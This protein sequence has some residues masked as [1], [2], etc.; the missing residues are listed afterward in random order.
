MMFPRFNLMATADDAGGA[1]V[2]DA[3]V[4]AA[5]PPADPATATPSTPNAARVALEAFR[6]KRAEKAAARTPAARDGEP[7]VA[8]V[9]PPELKSAADKWAA[10]EKAESSRITKAAEGLDDEDKALIAGEPDIT[11][12]AA[13]L[14][15]LSRAADASPAPKPVAK[16]KPAGG[17][18]SSSAVDF[19]AALKDPRAMADAKA[20]DP[21]GFEKFFSALLTG[22][23]RKSTLG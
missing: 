18:P 23:A 7:A 11:R 8:A 14:A 13:L 20:R 15:R 1:P 21:S 10:Y 12:K 16:P 17:P 6:A 19:A 5:T 9:V 22:N 2:G 3:T 4:T